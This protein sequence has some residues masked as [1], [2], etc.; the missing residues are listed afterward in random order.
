MWK[1]GQCCFRTQHNDSPLPTRSTSCPAT[2]RSKQAPEWVR[3]VDVALLDLLLWQ[4][5]PGEPQRP[6]E[7]TS[8]EVVD[9][10]VT[11][12][13]TTGTTAHR[14]LKHVAGFS[15]TPQINGAGGDMRFTS[16]PYCWWPRWRGRPPSSGPGKRAPA[17]APAS[18]RCTPRAS[19]GTWEPCL[20]ANRESVFSGFRPAGSRISTVY[21]P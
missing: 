5:V 18:P 7:D 12:R 20:W 17:A 13:K 16:C 8:L 10:H 21:R 6:R 1:R 9:H 4:R 11:V 19:P 3:D 15:D 2:A 14:C